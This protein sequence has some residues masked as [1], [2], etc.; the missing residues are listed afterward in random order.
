MSDLVPFTVVLIATGLFV[1]TAG[2]WFY[3]RT[4]FVRGDPE[5]Q[6]RRRKQATRW[7]LIVVGARSSSC[8]LAFLPAFLG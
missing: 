1:S 5:Q 7:T 2:M 6:A 4:I 3:R 8:G